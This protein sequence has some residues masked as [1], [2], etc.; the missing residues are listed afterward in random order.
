M[1][2]AVLSNRTIRLLVPDTTELEIVPAPVAG[3]WR[4]VTRLRFDNHDTASSTPTFYLREEDHEKFTTW[5]P[6]Q[7]RIWPART[8]V[9]GG[10]LEDCCGQ[11]AILDSTLGLTVQLAA[12]PSS[13]SNELLW[14]SVTVNYLDQVFGS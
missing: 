14:P 8:V 4:L 13:T 2:V 12:D 9:A 6:E 10:K 11:V 5:T 3:V 1:A 7:W